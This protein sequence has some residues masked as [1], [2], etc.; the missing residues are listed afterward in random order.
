MAIST[1]FPSQ[2][3]AT[4]GHFFT[5]GSSFLWV[6]PSGQISPQIKRLIG[7]PFAFH[8]EQNNT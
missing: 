6:S 8:E 1:F 2:N 7:P 3:M 5:S 4:L